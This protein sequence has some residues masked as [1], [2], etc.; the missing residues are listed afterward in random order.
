[1]WLMYTHRTVLKDNLNKHKRSRF[2]FQWYNLCSAEMSI[3]RQYSNMW[4][5]DDTETAA[6]PL[7]KDEEWRAIT[8]SSAALWL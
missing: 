1:M 2:V 3:Y 8:S 4:G 5:Q 6:H 7:E